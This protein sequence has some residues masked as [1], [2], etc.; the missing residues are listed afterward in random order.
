MLGAGPLA[1]S[2]S[3]ICHG[4]SSLSDSQV[5][6]LLVTVF[7]F[8][9][10]GKKG[11]WIKLPIGLANLVETAVK[12]IIVSCDIIITRIFNMLDSR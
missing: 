8:T 10:Q 12:V 1:S 2:F 9:S 6:L 11:A 7:E 5:P 3:L 4:F